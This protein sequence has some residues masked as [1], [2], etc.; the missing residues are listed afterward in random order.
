MTDHQ[1][2]R[3]R[4]FRK[5]TQERLAEKLGISRNLLSMYERKVRDVPEHIEKHI[6]DMR[7]LEKYED[8]WSE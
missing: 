2:K 1:L 4:E 5:L 3:F 6:A 7:K 8:Y